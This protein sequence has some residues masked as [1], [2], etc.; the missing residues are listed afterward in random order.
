[1]TPAGILIKEH[2]PLGIAEDLKISLLALALDFSVQITKGSLVD[3]KVVT[4]E[5]LHF[6]QIV[7]NLQPSGHRSHPVHHGRLR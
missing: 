5:E 1:M 7:K 2:G 4:V 6:E 3:L